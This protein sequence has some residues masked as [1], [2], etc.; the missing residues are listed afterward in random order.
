MTRYEREMVKMDGRGYG[1]LIA[2]A[3]GLVLMLLWALGVLF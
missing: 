3:T 1:H 2:L